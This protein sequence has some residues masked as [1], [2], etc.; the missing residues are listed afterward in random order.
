ML[1]L[2]RMLFFFTDSET[3]KES[4]LDQ[5]QNAVNNE[6]EKYGQVQAIHSDMER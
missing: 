3:I 5:D 4:N 2:L 6:I 1:P